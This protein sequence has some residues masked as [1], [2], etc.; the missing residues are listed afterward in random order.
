MPIR[1]VLI[2]DDSKSARLML[3][4]ML[5]GFGL[6]VDT[7][8]SAEDA[9][10]YLH[11]Q[12]PD[13]I[14]MDH[15]MPGLDGIGAVKQIK[16]DLATAAIPITMYTSKDEPSYKDEAHQA[17]A[18]GVLVKPATPDAL[19]VVLTQMNAVFEEV[20]TQIGS[21]PE[22]MTPM[23][24]A[25]TEGTSVEQVEKIALAKAELVVFDAIESQVLP[26]INDVIAKLRRE[27]KAN[28]E[29]NIGRISAQ[30]CDVRLAHFKPPPLDRRELQGAV[31]ATVQSQWLPLLKEQLDGFQS[32]ARAEL[33]GQARQIAG[34]VCQ[35][36]LHELSERLVRQLTARFTEATQK[37]EETTR[38]V[39]LQVAQTGALQAIAKT[40]PGIEQSNRA[41]VDEL[42]QQGWASAKQEFQRRIYVAAGWAAMIGIGAAALVYALR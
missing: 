5:Q 33:E 24:A 23:T 37:A 9:L 1:H 34:Q 41:M 19:G 8:D 7:V 17:G 38:E 42:F 15:T 18:V 2:V 28:Q 12:R 16:Q 4:K 25:V 14:F 6:T 31:D 35:T 20:A 39:A 26:L 10:H 13:A 40:T 27:A 32:S 29:E 11:A 36:Q 22:P 30:I 21:T 3:R